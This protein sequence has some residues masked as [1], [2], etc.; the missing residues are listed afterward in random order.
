M[1]PRPPPL[2]IY[3]YENQGWLVDS[4]F[5]ARADEKQLLFAPFRKFCV[6]VTWTV[7][8]RVVEL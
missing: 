2:L 5:Q 7:S 1:P 3:R 8:L 4:Y 6:S